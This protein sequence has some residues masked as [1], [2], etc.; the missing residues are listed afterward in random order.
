MLWFVIHGE[1][2]FLKRRRVL[3][4]VGM[5]FQHIAPLTLVLVLLVLALLPHLDVCPQVRL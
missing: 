2:D 3:F 5:E 1:V 4:L